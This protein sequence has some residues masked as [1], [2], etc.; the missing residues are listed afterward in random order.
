MK[1]AEVAGAPFGVIHNSVGT[2]PRLLAEAKVR[3]PHLYMETCPQFLLLNCDMDLGTIGKMNP[4]LRSAQDSEMLWSA[5]ANREIDWMGSDHCDYDR[6]AK[7][8]SI[9][10]AGPGLVSGVQMILPA[11]LSKGVNEGRITLERLVELTSANAARI[12]GFA[13]AKGT[14]DVGSDADMVVLDLDREV[15]LDAEVLNGFSDFTPYEGMKV[16]GWARTTIAGGEVVYDRGEV[17]DG[18]PRR[19]TVLRQDRSNPP[20]L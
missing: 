16:R 8:G 15:T 14:I 5:L 11:L 18:S 17:D 4:P 20:V 2:G 1:L 12:F 9:W 6:A 10:D 7:E 13:P 3:Y 19:G